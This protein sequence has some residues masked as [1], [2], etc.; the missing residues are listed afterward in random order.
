MT[1]EEFRAALLADPVTA[2]GKLTGAEFPEGFKL[3][4]LE[5]DPDYDMT[6]LLPPM[7]DDDLTEEEMD[8]VA[9]G[10]RFYASPLTK[11]SREWLRK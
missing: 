4:I 1:D 6:I 10:T 2:I 8:Q 9:G 5:Q 11:A 3:Q 7:V